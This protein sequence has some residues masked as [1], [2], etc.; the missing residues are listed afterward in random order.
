MGPPGRHRE[1]IVTRFRL[2]F[3][4]NRQQVLVALARDVVDRDLDLFL[5]GPLIDQ[6]G[7]GLVGAG[8]PM[9]PETNR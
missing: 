6:I 5:L 1:N 9:I 3:C 7:R 8:H 2:R 4:G